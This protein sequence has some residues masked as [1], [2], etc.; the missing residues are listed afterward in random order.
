MANP[1]VKE[2]D[3]IQ[4]RR[5][6]QDN[7]DAVSNHT[8]DASDIVSGTLSTDRFSAYAD[9][10]A[11]SKIGTAA[12]QVAPGNILDSLGTELPASGFANLQSNLD[13]LITKASVPD[14]VFAR[15]NFV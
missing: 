13:Y 12:D 6:V 4:Q 7:A 8:H 14:R 9:L 11:E 5:G 15:Q 10:V 1:R 3:Q 2:N